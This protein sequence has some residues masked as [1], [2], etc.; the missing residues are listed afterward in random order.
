[1][2]PD[3]LKILINFF[4]KDFLGRLIKV[5]DNPKLDYVD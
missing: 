4:D 2:S 5:M 1:M 3:L